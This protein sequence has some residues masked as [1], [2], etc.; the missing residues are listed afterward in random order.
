MEKLTTDP[1]SDTDPNM[2]NDSSTPQTR[3]RKSSVLE[4]FSTSA[5]RET[6][7]K[8]G[9]PLDKIKQQARTGDMVFFKGLHQISHAIVACDSQHNHERNLRHEPTYSHCAMIIQGK[10][11]NYENENFK[12]MME[13]EMLPKGQKF[14]PTQTYLFESQMVNG[15]MFHTLVDST[16]PSCRASAICNTLFCCLST[17]CG[18]SPTCPEYQALIYGSM[19]REIDLIVKEYDVNYDGQQIVGYAKTNSDLFENPSL[20]T[21]DKFT[22]LYLKLRKTPYPIDCCGVS[23]FAVAVR[24]IRPLRCLTKCIDAVVCC[25]SMRGKMIC[26]E[27]LVE[28][29]LGMG[30]L[31]GE[32][33]GNNVSPLDFIAPDADTNNVPADFLIKPTEKITYFPTEHA[34][35]AWELEKAS[36][37]VQQQPTRKLSQ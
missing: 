18:C 34:A 36:L 22:E 21:K 15:D 2:K 13:N 19:V 4:L 11:F 30:M 6:L 24:W 17:C 33:D 35:A 26:S 8:Q 14:D 7:Q 20:E 25:G 27:I 16:D 37:V 12:S 1:I 29:Y 31:E 10:D 32:I 23:I 5:N 28:F 9:I 3:K